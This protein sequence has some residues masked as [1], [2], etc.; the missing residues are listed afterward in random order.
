LKRLEGFI[1]SMFL[2]RLD[3]VLRDW[4]LLWLVNTFWLEVSLTPKSIPI[5]GA[6]LLLRQLR[7]MCVLGSYGDGNLQQY[8]CSYSSYVVLLVSILI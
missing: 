5:I 1:L 8:I 3:S 6:L 2:I 4:W 7:M